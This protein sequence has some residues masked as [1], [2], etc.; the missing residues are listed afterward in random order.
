MKIGELASA[1]GL[2]AKTIRYYELEGLLPR[3]PRTA[4]GYRTYASGD[5]QRLG[6]VAK[7]KRIGLTLRQIKE[8]LLLNDRNEPPRAHV[9][10][11]LDENLAEID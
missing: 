3:P 5:L 11:L 9:R 2:T 7:A 8:V 1:S 6:F 4:S 10:T